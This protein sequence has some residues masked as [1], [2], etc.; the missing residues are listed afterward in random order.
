M[1]KIDY[2]ITITR[3]TNW[4]DKKGIQY[5]KRPMQ[6]GWQLRFN[7]C[8][9]DVICHPYSIQSDN[10]MVETMGF[11]WDE[12]TQVTAWFPDEVSY[13]IT[14]LY[15]EIDGKIIKEKI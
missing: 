4:L 3:I 6:G 11:P 1:E 8:D 7:W 9:G 13:K 15:N 10:G 5:E 2:Y 14:K 12:E